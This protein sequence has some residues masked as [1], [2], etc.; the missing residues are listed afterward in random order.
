[1]EVNDTPSPIIELGL[2][3][4]AVSLGPGLPPVPPP[5]IVTV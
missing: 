3:E 4:P 1:M 5:P 2:P